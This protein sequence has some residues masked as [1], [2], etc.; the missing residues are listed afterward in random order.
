MARIGYKGFQ[1]TCPYHKDEGDPKG[2]RCTRTLQHGRAGANDEDM[3]LRS[4]KQWCLDGRFRVSRRLADDEGGHK[5][6]ATCAELP[7]NADLD[8]Q[9]E[10]ALSEPNWILIA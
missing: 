10:A 6:V 4:L 7:T 1:V 2:T 8:A 9:L 3:V 5:G